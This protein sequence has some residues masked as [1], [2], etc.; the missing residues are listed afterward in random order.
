M[1]KPTGIFLVDLSGLNLPEYD[2][3]AINKEIN[4]VVQRHL[5]KLDKAKGLKL[6]SFGGPLGGGLMGYFPPHDLLKQFG[7]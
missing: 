6:A 4:E 3:A 5:G 1:A 2:L 7:G